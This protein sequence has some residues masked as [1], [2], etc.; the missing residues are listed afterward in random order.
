MVIMALGRFS[1]FSS[2]AQSTALTTEQYGAL[3]AIL[4]VALYINGRFRLS[5]PG[6]II[7][8][9]GAILMATMAWDVG[10][11]SVTSVFELWMALILFRET[12]TSHDC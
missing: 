3:L 11:L 1:V 9:L 4:G 10:M 12:F 6:R 5:V 8:A 2:Q 7:A